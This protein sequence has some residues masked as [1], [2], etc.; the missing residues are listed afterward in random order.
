[1]EIFRFTFRLPGGGVL[2]HLIQAR[3]KG[4][5]WRM[6]REAAESLGARILECEA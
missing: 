1:M 6:A 4:E 5:A 2:R 3:R